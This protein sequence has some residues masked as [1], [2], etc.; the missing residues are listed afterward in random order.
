MEAIVTD[1]FRHR[2][3][4]TGAGLLS[5]GLVLTV[6]GLFPGS[7]GA[8]HVSPTE[9]PN[10]AIADGKKNPSCA[11]VLP[12]SNELRINGVPVEGETYEDAGANDVDGVPG[13]LDVEI[14]DVSTDEK[15]L[16]WESN[17]DVDAVLVKGGDGGNL[18]LYP[19]TTDFDDSGLITP[20]NSGDD[21]QQRPQISHVSFCYDSVSGPTTTVEETTTTTEGTTTTTEGTTTTT[22]ATTTTETPTTTAVTP[23]TAAAFVL[24]EQ[25]TTTT[26]KVLGVQQTRQLAATGDSTRPLLL[27]AGFLLALGGTAL[28]AGRQPQAALAGEGMRAP[29]LA[30]L[31]TLARMALTIEGHQHRRR[32]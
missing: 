23:T 10:A 8:T 21:G 25:I 32:S 3:R 5:L 7:A 28:L 22:V 14:T 17:L 9:Y 12:G 27:L 30:R 26:V 15:S 16:S 11:D 2:R 4:A 24:N 18:Y 13:N 31:L 29:T 1:K 20:Q 6:L 19:G